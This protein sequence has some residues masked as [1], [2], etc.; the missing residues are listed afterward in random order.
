MQSSNTIQVAGMSAAVAYQQFTVGMDASI[1]QTL[2]QFAFQNADAR[3]ASGQGGGSDVSGSW[4]AK[5][6]GHMGRVVI[7]VPTAG[8]IK[9]LLSQWNRRGYAIDRAF[10]PPRLDPMDHRSFWQG[11]DVIVLGPIPA[12]AKARIA[13]RFERGTTIVTAVVEVGQQTTNAARGGVSY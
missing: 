4:R 10:V 3:A 8:R 12:D 13:A 5:N 7:K 2:P 1:H 6:G 11:E 9:T